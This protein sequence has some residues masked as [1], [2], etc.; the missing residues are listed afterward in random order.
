MNKDKILTKSLLIAF[1]LSVSYSV[2]FFIAMKEYHIAMII[3]RRD[4]KPNDRFP[5]MDVDND[6][7]KHHL[8]Y[9]RHRL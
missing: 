4:T 3:Y 5:Q 7:P 6:L 9:E 2:R 8:A 1:C